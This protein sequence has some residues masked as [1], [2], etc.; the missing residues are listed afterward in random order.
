M[1]EEP[2][3]STSRIYDELRHKSI[4]TA[5]LL[6]TLQVNKT[7]NILFGGVSAAVETPKSVTEVWGKT[8][9]QRNTKDMTMR[10]I[11][12]VCT[13]SHTGISKAGTTIQEFQA[14]YGKIFLCCR[15]PLKPLNITRGNVGND[16]NKWYY[17]SQQCLS[18]MCVWM[19]VCEY[20]LVETQMLMFC[21]TCQKSIILR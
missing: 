16:T 8:F 6:F 19:T 9:T 7:A 13:R 2:Y 20:M 1:C 11:T 18:S 5:I 4:D 10:S 12:S 14:W 3:E 15:P 21:S 17:T